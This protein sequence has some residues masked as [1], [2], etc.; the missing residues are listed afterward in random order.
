M[1]LHWIPAKN[2]HLHDLPKNNHSCVLGLAE[3]KLTF[4]VA[5]H[6][7]LWFE[8][9]TKTA[10]NLSL[11]LILPPSEKAGSGQKA[12]TR[13]SPELS[14]AGQN[15]ALYHIIPYSAKNWEVLFSNI[16]IVWSLAGHQSPQWESGCLSITWF[17]PIFSP[18][19]KLCF[20]WPISFYLLSFALP[21]L[22]LSCW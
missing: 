10:P 16:T 19:T 15:S 18:L 11:V 2:K 4:F 3:M 22:S 5:A 6:M 12:G 1:Q 17:F 20:S 7:V 8:F 14:W 13:H 21:I 9:G